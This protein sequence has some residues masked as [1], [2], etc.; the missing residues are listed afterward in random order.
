MGCQHNELL[1]SFRFV[2][3][4]GNFVSIAELHLAGSANIPWNMWG[5]PARHG[6]KWMMSWG[7]PHGWKPPGSC[8]NVTWLRF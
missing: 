2:S 5:F 3:L 1:A 6:G 4:N 7:Y 8:P